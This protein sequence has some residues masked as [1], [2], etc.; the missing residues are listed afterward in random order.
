MNPV[1]EIGIEIRGGLGFFG[2]NLLAPQGTFQSNKQFKYDGSWIKGSHVIRFGAGVNRIEGGGFAAFFGTAPLDESSQSHCPDPTSVAACTLTLAILGNGQGFFTE[3]PGFGL[4]AGGQSDTR[5]SAYVGDSWKVKPNFTLT[6]G[7]RYNRDTGRTDSDLAPIPCSE[8]SSAITPAPCSGSSSL[9]DQWQPGFGAR[10]RQPNENFGPQVGFA[11]DPKSDGKT[12]IRAGV[13]IYYE[14]SIFNNTLFDRP[15]KLAQG[16]FSAQA[17][18]ICG[19]GGPGSVS[20]QYTP[21]STPVTSIDGLDLATQVCGQPLSVAG[22][23]TADLQKAYQAAIAAAGPSANP[24]FV[25]NT[26]SLSTAVSG[27]AAYSPNY[28]TPRS[29]QFNIGG[30]RQLW[31]GSVL[32]ADY[33]R[34]VSV[35]FP[36]TIDVNHVGDARFLNVTAAQNAIGATTGQFGCGGGFDSAS[37]DCAIGAGATINDFAGNGLDSGLSYLS[38]SPAGVFGLTPDTGAAFAGQNPLMGVGD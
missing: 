5:F 31:K 2:P 38:G 8:V 9:F 25:G 15:G 4:P 35:H 11:W 3:K 26:L 27:L 24:N 30:Q 16:L 17:L 14:N 10:I 21:S 28:Q 22:Q 34:D 23:P 19:T 18:L 13:G 37:I 33:I 12:V 20:V 29:Y 36:L 1:P 7:L 32:T 6:Y